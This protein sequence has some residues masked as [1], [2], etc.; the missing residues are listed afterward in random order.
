MWWCCVQ[1]SSVC[2]CG[3]L[4]HLGEDVC[5]MLGEPVF[6]KPQEIFL[7]SRMETQSWLVEQDD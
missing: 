1:R 4:T 5:E 3:E 6:Y 7:G 2:S